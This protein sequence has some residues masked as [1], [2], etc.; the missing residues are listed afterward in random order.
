MQ[1]PGRSLI[2]AGAAALATLFIA[3]SLVDLYVEALWFNETG[4]AS[5]F[6]TRT[7]AG[8]AT[9]L[10]AALGAAI[11]AFSNLA[12]LIRRRGAIQLR[13]EYGNLEIVE[14]IPRRWVMAGAIAVSAL[15]GW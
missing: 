6:W 5:S 7:I 15:A 3:G 11:L 10:T 4:F 1:R 9:R 8:W 2:I 13:R 12:Y 14:Q